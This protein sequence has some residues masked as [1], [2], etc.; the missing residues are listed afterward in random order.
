[1][2][3]RPDNGVMSALQDPNHAAFGPLPSRC[4]SGSDSGPRVSFIASDPHN[5]PIAM[6]RRARIFGRDKNIRLARFVCDQKTVTDLM[7]RQFAG[8]KIG[9]GWQYI[10]ILPNARDFAVALQFTEDLIECHAYA[11]LASQL[12]RQLTL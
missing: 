11:A 8:D 9:L 12:F 1:M 10:T 6:H 5:D 2:L 3:K 4:Q 7:D